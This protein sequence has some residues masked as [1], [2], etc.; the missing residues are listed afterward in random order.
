MDGFIKWL[1]MIFVIIKNNDYK[2][3]LKHHDSKL[4]PKLLVNLQ[5]WE[6]VYVIRIIFSSTEHDSN[7]QRHI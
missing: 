7:L 1:K 6:Q 3:N 4:I 2:R 5:I